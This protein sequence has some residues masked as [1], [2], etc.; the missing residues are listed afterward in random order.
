[1]AGGFAIRIILVAKGPGH[2]GDRACLIGARAGFAELVIGMSLLVLVVIL[3]FVAKYFF[4]KRPKAQILFPQRR[5]G[6]L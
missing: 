2:V 6:S 4:V 3:A 5:G 1:M